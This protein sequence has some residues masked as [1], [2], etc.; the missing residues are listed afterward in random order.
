MK[1]KNPLKS[2]S[3]IGAIS[4]DLWTMNRD[5]VF[6]NVLITTN[7]KVAEDYAHATWAVKF[8]AEKL[9]AP[10]NEV[11]SSSAPFD[12]NKIK[13]QLQEFATNYP[14]PI[15]VTSLAILITIPYLLY[16][17]CGA[18]TAEKE[19]DEKELEEL[20]AKKKKM[21]SEEKKRKN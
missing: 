4:F 20:V 14:I 21:D 5:T 7:E 19:E 13:N 9:L 1:K 8:E 16:Q 18:L 12:L 6:D 2:L 17:C 11:T 10:K 3:N 15:I